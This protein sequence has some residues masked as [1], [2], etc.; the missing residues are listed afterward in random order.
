MIAIV[1]YGM[2]NLRSVQ[3]AFEKSGAKARITS[4]KTDI[5]NASK[6]VLPGVGAFSA[7]VKEL[8]KRRIV[9][10][11][12][13]KIEWG[14]PYLGLCLGLQLLFTHSDEGRGSEGLGIIDGPVKRFTHK[15]K[16]PHM[17]WNTV[18]LAQKNC[19]LF[20][21][22]S[23]DAYFYFVHSY[24]GV[25]RDPSWVLT[26]TEYGVRFCSSIWKNRSSSHFIT[27]G[28]DGLPLKSDGPP[29]GHESDVVLPSGSVR[30]GPLERDCPPSGDE[31][32]VLSSTGSSRVAS[33]ERDRPPSGDQ[34]HVAL[35]RG[36]SRGAPLKRDDPPSRHVAFHEGCRGFSPC[37]RHGRVTFRLR[38]I[39]SSHDRT[40]PGYGIHV[41]CS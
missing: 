35:K 31:F 8:E 25:P 39:R 17:G 23:K 12:L 29:S 21:G 32:H 24:Y 40:A 4:S 36:S 30:G 18:T 15:L 33:L 6:V 34:F 22:T 20:D 37:E 16:I 3:K 2:G 1:D 14:T 7:A 10:V 26:S 28:R 38:S 27:L 19:P 41:A 13:N 5:H 11:L 9:D